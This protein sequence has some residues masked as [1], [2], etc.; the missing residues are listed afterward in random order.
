[1]HI[2]INDTPSTS[3]GYSVTGISYCVWLPAVSLQN[4]LASQFRGQASNSRKK[5]RCVNCGSC[6]THD[7]SFKRHLRYECQQDPRF[8]CPSCDFRSRWTF[9]VYNHV[10][11]RHQGT[12][13]RCIDIGKNWRDESFSLAIKISLCTARRKLHFVCNL[14]IVNRI[15]ISQSK[16]L[17]LY[18]VPLFFS[19]KIVLSIFYTMYYILI[20]F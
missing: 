9:N 1:M 11:K 10:R 4:N 3:N 12:V 17:P 16:N 7:R 15:K 2:L 6:F 18:H 19:K 8:K 5:F 14:I 20:S 13:V